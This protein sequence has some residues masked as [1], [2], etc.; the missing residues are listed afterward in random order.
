MTSQEASPALTTLL[1]HLS[2]PLSTPA[3]PTLH[4]WGWKNW[5]SHHQARVFL[6]LVFMVQNLSPY[7]LQ[8]LDLSDSQK[9]TFLSP[10]QTQTKYF[11]K[12]NLGS[13]N[14]CFRCGFSASILGVEG[15]HLT[16]FIWPRG[17]S[18]PHPQGQ[19]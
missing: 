7:V 10:K 19:W 4:L 14:Y 17:V 8:I 13:Q 11:Y 12:Q 16:V 15:N 3:P 5:L 18:G 6:T 9:N 2:S 1:P